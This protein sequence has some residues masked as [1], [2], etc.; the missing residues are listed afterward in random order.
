MGELQPSSTATEHPHTATFA[1]TPVL[2]NL[3][4]PNS[5]FVRLG[6][7]LGIAG[8]V[9]GF[10]VLVLGCAGIEKALLASR[11]V[12]GLGA[13][14]LFLSLVGGLFQRRRLVEDTHF[15]H[16]AFACILA[17]VGGLLEMVPVMHW[18]LFK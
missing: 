5:P 13:V 11:A 9:I 2:S 16:A 14:G 8:T 15:L 7:L 10:V 3:K 17:I 12:V 4:T 6:G 18:H 1:D